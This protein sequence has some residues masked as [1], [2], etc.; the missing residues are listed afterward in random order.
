[1]AD[2]ADHAI[3]LCRTHRDNIDILLTDVVMPG[4]SGPELAKHLLSL[5]PGLRVIYMSGYAG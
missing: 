1:V 4:V 2:S 3:E 5:R